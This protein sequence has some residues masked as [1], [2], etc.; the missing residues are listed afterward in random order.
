MF[1]QVSIRAFAAPAVAH[2][3][4]CG[5]ARMRTRT[6]GTTSAMATYAHFAAFAKPSNKR[7]KRFS[8]HLSEALR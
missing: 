8:R 4:V 1:S 2:A 6:M 3:Y 7:N 5:D